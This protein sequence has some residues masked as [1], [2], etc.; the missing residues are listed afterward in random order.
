MSDTFECL[1]SLGQLITSSSK[2]SVAEEAC[3]LHVMEKWLSGARF[4]PASDERIRPIGEV[5]SGRAS[6]FVLSKRWHRRPTRVAQLIV[7]S[8]MVIA[9]ALT[10]EILVQRSEE[11]Y[12]IIRPFVNEPAN[13]R[14]Y[15]AILQLDTRHEDSFQLSL[16]RNGISP[17]TT[18]FDQSAIGDFLQKLFGQL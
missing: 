6:Q 15:Q 17:G 14:G 8:R 10:A 1:F 12:V 4:V 5:K 11:N 16:R 9:S 18:F 13:M 3:S 2:A 7:E